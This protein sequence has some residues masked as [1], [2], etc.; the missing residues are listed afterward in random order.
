LLNISFFVETLRGFPFPNNSVLLPDNVAV[1]NSEGQT[2]VHPA[3]TTEHND[4]IRHISDSN[5]WSP[6][7][8]QT[9]EVAQHLILR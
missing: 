6:L 4:N 8:R 9:V 2:V 1:Y 3:Q 5:V 7:K